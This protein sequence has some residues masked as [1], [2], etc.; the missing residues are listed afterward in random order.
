MAK[1]S[2]PRSLRLRCGPHVIRVVCNPD[3]P[4]QHMWG[5]YTE[6]PIGIELNP[7]L[8]GTMLCETFLHECCH[9]VAE[10][11]GP[12]LTERQVHGL[13]A[14]LAQML[15]D[16]LELPQSASELPHRGAPKR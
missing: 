4:E 12:G 7:N 8:S 15:K 16:L 2:S 6:N 10:T 9:A 11:F 1:R 5:C 3:L 14:G 13:G